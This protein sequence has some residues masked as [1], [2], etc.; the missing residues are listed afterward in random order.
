MTE[1][2]QK[3]LEELLDAIT[4]KFNPASETTTST[5]DS[6]CESSVE[7][8]EVS[9]EEVNTATTSTET[10]SF[11]LSEDLE[12]DATDVENNKKSD[13]D[14]ISDA[15]GKVY[16][17]E[18]FNDVMA[19]A[20]TEGRDV[21]ANAMKQNAETPIDN[22]EEAKATKQALDD[23]LQDLE[24]RKRERLEARMRRTM[25]TETM[26]RKEAYRTSEAMAKDLGNKAIGVTKAVELADGTVEKYEVTQIE[27]KWADD[28]YA[29][30]TRDNFVTNIEILRATVTKQLVKAAGGLGNIKKLYVADE[31][32]VINNVS[33]IPKLGDL[34]KNK[35]LFPF[36]A[37]NYI[38]AGKLAPL[39]KW[40]VLLR[41]DIPN[42]S[43]LS[44]DT[45]SFFNTYMRSAI[46]GTT[47]SMEDIVRMMMTSLYPKLY[48]CQIGKFSI[49]RDDLNKEQKDLFEQ[50]KS[51]RASKELRRLEKQYK[52]Q[53]IFA[54]M[55]FNLY[56]ATAGA[57]KFFID[58]L[59]NYATHR[60]NKSFL[61]YGLGVM[62]RTVGI[63][64]S[65]AVAGGTRLVGRGI[66]SLVHGA[67]TSVSEEDLEALRPKVK[68]QETTSS[69][70][71]DFE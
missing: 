32:L 41:K 15:D 26:A 47:H 20:Q 25:S 52:K 69:S 19:R 31:R 36:D 12:T 64:G 45:M 5:E 39:I 6:T 62:L 48:V 46:G 22:S 65:L 55:N 49:T 28:M 17:A 54:D 35:D 29:K 51:E 3:K 40:E 71:E 8:T 37:L 2:K 33:Y 42:L 63:A 34:E 27:P 10:T 43:T 60:G 50:R 56:D 66:P 7:N 53:H 14:Y 70:D 38:K 23:L 21:T 1:T 68:K 11:D 61:R 59:K 57:N 16:D 18:S 58:S 9:S 24:E 4:A 44:V 67:L 13:I 30:L